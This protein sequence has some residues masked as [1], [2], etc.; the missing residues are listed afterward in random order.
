MKL[1]PSFMRTRS[2]EM[3]IQ[4]YVAAL[5]AKHIVLQAALSNTR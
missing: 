4:F 1:Y 3:S 5:P 2:Y